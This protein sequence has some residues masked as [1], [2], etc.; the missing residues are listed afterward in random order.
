MINFFIPI[1]KLLALKWYC[2]EK[3]MLIN[4]LR[5][6]GLTNVIY[7]HGQKLLGRSHYVSRK[8]KTI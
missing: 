3:K 2:K 6:K 5:L 4:C 1:T 8:L 7:N